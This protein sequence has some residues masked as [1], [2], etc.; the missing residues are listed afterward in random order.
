MAEFDWIPTISAVAAAVSAIASASSANLARKSN[1]FSRRMINQE[2]GMFKRQF[3]F[4]L[5]KT[6]DRIR[7]IDPDAPN[8]EDALDGSSALRLTAA[9]WLHDVM[10]KNILHQTYSQ[11]YYQIYDSLYMITR[12]LPTYNKS[13]RELLTQAVQSVYQ[14]MKDKDNAQARPV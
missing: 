6:W 2:E 3:V 5:H 14:E 9:V 10:D 8:L 11:D 12:D 7:E 1:E 4:E 13:G